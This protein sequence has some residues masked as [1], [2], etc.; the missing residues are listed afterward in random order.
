MKYIILLFTLLVSFNASAITTQDLTGFSD[1][2]D[3]QKAEIAKT[4]A[5][6]AAQNTQ[7]AVEVPDIQQ[8]EKY[9]DIGI[10]IAKA[11]GSAAKELNVAINDFLHTPAGII[12]TGLIVYKVLGADVMEQIHAIIRSFVFT[13]IWVGYLIWYIRRNSDYRV[14]YFEDKYTWYGTQKVK[15]VSR[16]GLSDERSWSITVVSFIC[17]AISVILL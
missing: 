15:T 2:S 7:K 16:D 4:I 12:S 6:Q 8:V 9:T 14:E 17:L 3:V 5:A 11:L 10:N 1:L 13:V